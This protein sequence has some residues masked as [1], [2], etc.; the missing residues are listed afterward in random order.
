MAKTSLNPSVMLNRMRLRTES[1]GMPMSQYVPGAILADEASPA[2]SRLRTASNFGMPVSPYAQ[3]DGDAMDTNLWCS[4]A[5][6]TA[7]LSA[8]LGTVGSGMGFDGSALMQPGACSKQ[9]ISGPPVTLPMPA[10][11]GLGDGRYTQAEQQ[12]QEL[13]FQQQ[14]QQRQQPL[15]SQLPQHDLQAEAPSPQPVQRLQLGALTEKPSPMSSS[16]TTVM[17]RNLPDGMTHGKLLELLDSQG[18][19]GRYDF[20]YLPVAFDTL[21][22]M[23]FAFVNMA[24][25]EDA[26]SIRSHLEGFKWG[27]SSTAVCRVVWNDKQQ[28]LQALVERYRNSPVMHESVPDECKPIL[29]TGGKR[30]PFPPPTQKIKAPKNLKGKA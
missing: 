13:R 6:T 23:D 8:L 26:Q 30:V 18:F 29:I 1:F 10:M 3:F 17:L 25:P 19:A 27:A 21:A 4:A 15:Q 12:Q 20:A 5:F 2:R 7:D 24:T 22:A 16:W 11:A 9:V 28:G 14:Q